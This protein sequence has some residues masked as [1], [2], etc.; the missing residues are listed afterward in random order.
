MQNREMVAETFSVS[1]LLIFGLCPFTSLLYFETQTYLKHNQQKPQK[2]SK[3]YTLALNFLNINANMET[4]CFLFLTNRIKLPNMGNN[5]CL[6][7]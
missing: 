6:P 2:C 1:I 5:Q 7:V 4:C 3:F